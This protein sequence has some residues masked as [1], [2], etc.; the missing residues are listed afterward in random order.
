MTGIPDGVAFIRVLGSVQVVTSSGDVV[1]LPSVSQRRLLS[2]LALHARHS[3]RSEWLADMLDLSSGALRTSVSR[4]RKLLGDA[5][6]VTTTVGYRLDL[7]V[8][9]E[10]FAR[11][12]AEIAG[13]DAASDRIEG[14]ERTLAFWTGPALE[15][16]AS[17][18]WASGDAAR[19]TELHASATEDLAAALIAV[20]LWSDAVAALEAH[21]AAHPLRDRPRGLLMEALAGEGRQ[22]DALRA[23]QQYRALLA[24][25]IGTEPSAEVRRIE[26]RIA[27][28]WAG[29]DVDI[30]LH[31]ALV[32][33]APLVGRS[34]EWA[35]FNDDVEHARSGH[36][37][38]I[39]LGGE[40]G[41]GKTTLLAAFARA[42]HDQGD[43]T[44]LYARCDDGAA[45]PLQPF[46]SL[47]GY[48]VDHVP[49]AL[50]EAHTARCGGE[51]QRIAPEIAVRVPIPELVSSDDAT[52][53][54]LLF[55][56]VADLLRRVA[57]D[58]VLVL[59]LDDLHWAE[60]TALSLLRH[61]T[62][63][64]AAAPVLL[65]ASSRDS[66]EHV[67]D[68]LRLALADLDRGDSRRVSLRGFD[69]SELA[70]LVASVTESGVDAEVVARLRVDSAGNPLYATQLIRYWDESGSAPN[71]GEIPPSLRDVVWSR[72]VA[73]GPA[74]SEVLSAG[75]VLGAEFSEAVVSELVDVD[76]TDLDEA[77][78]AAVA[79]GLLVTAEPA[80]GTMRFVHAL[81]ANALYSQLR[82]VQ[83]RR[84][85]ERAARAL[86]KSA[87]ELPQKTVVQLARHCALG[88]LLS[89]ALRWA[90]AAGDYAFEHLAPSEAAMWY[91]VALDH[92]T[93]LERPDGERADLIV[94]MGEAQ[95]RAGDPQALPTLRLG[96]ELAETCGASSVLVRAALATDRG[97][98]RIGAWAPEQLAIVESAVAVAD[99]QDVTTY[100]RLLALFAQSLIHTSRARTRE[101]VARQALD[102][103][104][105]SSDPTLLP[106]V[107]SPVLYALWASGAS[108]LRAD[109]A[110]RAVAAAEASGDQVLEFAT[111]TAAY[112][113]SIQLADPGA[114]A[115][116]LARL[117]AIAAHV[118]EPHMRWTVGLDETFDAT[119]AARLDDAER[120]AGETLELGLQ[121][122][123]PDAF[124][125]YASEFFVIGTFG[126]RHA[127]LF[128]IV[129]QAA[130]DAPAL[131]PLRLAYGI[132][133]AVVGRD[134][135]ARE[136]LA[137][138]VVAGFSNIPPDLLWMTSVIGYAVLAVE[139]HDA[140][141]AAELF[142]IVEPFAA[143]VAYSGATSQGPIAAYLGKLASLLG[144]HDLADSYLRDALDTAVA[145]GWEY[146]H[147]TTL[148]AMAQ[149]R[150][151]RSG[152]LDGD[153]HAWL[154]EA[155]AIC[156]ERG[157]R[158]WAAEIER[159]RS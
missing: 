102:L 79:A 127:E 65:I 71:D 69:D 155:D 15:E 47:I 59:M 156:R 103:A 145:F 46:R 100:A 114:A 76:G 150:L 68:D 132:I 123:E 42:L 60:P 135:T 108:T 29:V 18:E 28:T 106:R 64:L 111:H 130:A 8:D 40:A 87:D 94:R 109:V 81:V 51:L 32:D 86:R 92:A 125:I 124:A 9:A 154:D 149:S 73:L 72:V 50:L 89:D 1:D 22:A 39:L 11:G 35:W 34:H 95:H 37:R 12:I 151:R 55:E 17:E 43:G 23:F 27:T 48:C 24:D 115:R 80:S 90:T 52:A 38:T 19:L 75:A 158:S 117:R 139:L 140:D 26:Q 131:H 98:M 116:S 10:M 62:R 118:G 153:A 101:D 20:Q 110:A 44:V 142:P 14:F 157:L 96:A 126:G 63:A 16:F 3:L 152:G 21:I 2:V 57:A 107:A 99:P 138:G 61:L 97:F 49:T 53:R 120:L 74:P 128:P 93:A 56:A 5:A 30:P 78:D 146:H 4:L 13:A 25:E 6:L 143:E 104:T 141:A 144:R 84:L 133:C 137:E 105:S 122:G 129:E 112:N 113:V 119:M 36:L 159:L 147:A 82:P 85:H 70:E 31:G 54:Y 91:R 41:I 77:L 148:I 136:I 45:V 7:D 121:I 66:H 83:R 67:S 33:G 134:D 88:G 58:G